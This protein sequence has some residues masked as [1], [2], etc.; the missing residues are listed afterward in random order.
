MQTRRFWA[1]FWGLFVLFAI[2]VAWFIG[3]L[4]Y[5]LL[6]AALG[7]FGFPVTEAQTVTYIAAHL[8]PFVLIL[9]V[10]GVLSLL[11]QKQIAHAVQEA[12]PAG[13]TFRELEAQHEIAAA[14]NRQAEALEGQARENDP[15]VKMMRRK[16][17]QAWL[18]RVI[19]LSVGTAHEYYDIPQNGLYS[20][21]RRFKV[22]F[23]NADAH[24]AITNG[25]LQIISIEPPCGYRG[26]WLIKDGITIA[27]GDHDFLPLATYNE[28]REPEKGM[29]PE[30]TFKIESLPNDHRQPLLGKENQPHILTLRATA[31]DVPF[32][33]LKCK[34]WIDDHCKFQIEEI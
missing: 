25:K 34:L 21:K 29:T 15:I 22:K 3:N 18:P 5:T 13:S 26:P 23:E 8:L 20:F 1:L 28:L 7:D 32:C 9:V 31:S 33:D 19:K 16:Q 17:E 2:L 24:K 12:K 6:W 27:A 14:I 30:D 4:V 10:G 11:V